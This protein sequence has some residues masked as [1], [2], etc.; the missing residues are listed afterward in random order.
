MMSKGMMKMVLMDALFGHR[1]VHSR[2]EKVIYSVGDHS[3]PTTVWRVL[4][5]VVERRTYTPVRGKDLINR[6][7]VPQVVSPQPRASGFT[8]PRA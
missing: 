6:Q 4:L 3:K 7:V 2:R 1:S 8:F 5:A